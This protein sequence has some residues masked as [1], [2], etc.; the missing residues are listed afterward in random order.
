[1]VSKRL[2]NSSRDSRDDGIITPLDVKNG[3]VAAGQPIG[4]RNAHEM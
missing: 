1:M 4:N 3:V 2:S